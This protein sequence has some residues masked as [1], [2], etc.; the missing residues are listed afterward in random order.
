MTHMTEQSRMERNTTGVRIGEGL[1]PIIPSIHD[2]SVQ[3]FG[4]KWYFMVYTSNMIVFHMSYAYH[5]PTPSLQPTFTHIHI[6]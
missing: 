1:S 3:G 5:K 2:T 6:I 4:I